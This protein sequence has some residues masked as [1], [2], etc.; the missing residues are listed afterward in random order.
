MS[1][2]KVKP[3]GVLLV[4][5]GT[6]CSPDRKS[7]AR[8]LKEFLSDQRVVPLPRWLWQPLLRCV[9]L[10]LRATKVAKLYQRIWWKAGSPLRVITEQQCHALAASLKETTGQTLPVAMAMRYGEPSLIKGLTVL[11]E[12]G[13]GGVVVLPLF[14]QYSSSTTASVFD[15]VTRAFKKC[16]V[17]PNL[18]FVP[19]YYNEPQYIAA[20]AETI[21]NHWTTQG[22]RGHLLFSFH[23]LP[24]SFADKGDPYP[25]QCEATAQGV[26]SV[27]GLT[28]TE[29]TMAYQSRVG[30][31]AWLQPYTDRTLVK[32]AKAGHGQV[33]VISPGFAADCLETLEELEET[34]RQLFLAA[35][36]QVFH[37]IP[38]L[39]AC[40]AHIA[41]L[42]TLVKKQWEGM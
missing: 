34:N 19:S 18:R 25:K 2:N 5:L 24:Q 40:E 20:L 27:L 11:R 9:V 23:G 21:K 16:P 13:C 15:G 41:C 35:G 38:A 7:V 1:Q 22:R 6:P 28:K 33:D 39:N 14:P 31:A 37:Y 42:T 8:F 30:L 26:A 17:L 29:W 10:P 12:A 3:I 36:G 32:L 4:N